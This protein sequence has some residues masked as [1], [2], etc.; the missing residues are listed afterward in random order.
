MEFMIFE[1]MWW[2]HGVRLWKKLNWE[3]KM[4]KVLKMYRIEVFFLKKTLSIFTKQTWASI[5]NSRIT[6]I[7][8][9]TWEKLITIF[10]FYSESR[11]ELT[12][13]RTWISF[14][15][16]MKI[17]AWLSFEWNVHRRV[18]T[19]VNDM[20]FLTLLKFKFLP[21]SFAAADVDDLPPEHF[22]IL[23]SLTRENKKSWV[24]SVKNWHN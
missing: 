2:S 17:Y 23:C 16:Y 8:N 11:D 21:S 22:F 9:A 13:H 24:K 1:V 12:L 7:K 3:F 19:F 10:I 14:V 5:K 6:L 4:K 20:T 15:L 18:Y